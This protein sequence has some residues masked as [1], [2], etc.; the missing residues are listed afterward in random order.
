MVS[1]N[2]KEMNGEKTFYR[3][4]VQG[5]GTVEILVQ[6]SEQFL[7]TLRKI[8]LAVTTRKHFCEDMLKRIH[9]NTK[10]IR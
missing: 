3:S 2:E 4:K 7:P 5:K 10:V 9:H 1:I 8:E 6:R